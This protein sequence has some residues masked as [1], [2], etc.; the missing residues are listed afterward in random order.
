MNTED[1]WKPIEELTKDLSNSVHVAAK[2]S[3]PYNEPNRTRKVGNV[4]QNSWYD[5]ECKEKRDQ[6]QIEVARETTTLKNSRSI[7]RSLVKKKHKP[8]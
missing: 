8:S 4:P 3:F 6:M 2:A 1:P 7:L 5:E